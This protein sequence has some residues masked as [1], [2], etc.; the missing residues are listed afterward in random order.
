MVN[1]EFSLYSE[2]LGTWTP[3]VALLPD[4]RDENTK[5]FYLLHGLGCDQ[6]KWSTWINVERYA[7]GRNVALIMPY[8]QRSFYCNMKHGYKF[9]TYIAEELP[10]KIG[11]M[12]NLKQTCENTFLCGYS[13]GAYGAARIGLTQPGKF[14]GIGLLSGVLDVKGRLNGEWWDADAKLIW[15]DDYKT[16]VPGSEDDPVC[17]VKK[18]YADK[19]LPRIFHTCGTDDFLYEDNQVFRREMA[20]LKGADYLYTEGP[21]GHANLF[22]NEHITE[23]FDFLLK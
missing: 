22:W 23:M 4:N 10:R 6:R 14:K 9:Y 12:F 20:S 11:A 1:C 13:M 19:T 16:T 18:A 5:V 15:G 8:G 7:E 21:G 2:A 17:L 3:V